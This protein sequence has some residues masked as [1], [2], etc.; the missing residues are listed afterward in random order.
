V[1][2]PARTSGYFGTRA[3]S[4]ALRRQARAPGQ[5]TDYGR[6]ALGDGLG[7][8]DTTGEGDTLGVAELDGVGVGLGRGLRD[9]LGDRVGLGAGGVELGAWVGL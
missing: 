4:P 6:V 3:R 9:G 8:P 5:R 1:V 7:G 2:R